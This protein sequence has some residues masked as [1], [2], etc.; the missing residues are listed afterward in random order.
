MV[1]LPALA[2]V[3]VAEEKKERQKRQ[4]SQGLEAATQGSLQQLRNLAHQEQVSLGSWPW[5]PDSP[6]FLSWMIFPPP[7]NPSGAPCCHHDKAAWLSLAHPPSVGRPLPTPTMPLSPTLV[8]LPAPPL[9]SRPLFACCSQVPVLSPEP[10]TPS[11]YSSGSIWQAC[12][13]LGID[14]ATTSSS[15]ISCWL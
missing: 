2:F 7:E 12:P 15:C 8:I 1:F 10:Q 9:S 13:C 6:F 3:G 11:F 4:V 14:L 5:P